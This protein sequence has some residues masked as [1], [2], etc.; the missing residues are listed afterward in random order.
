MTLLELL[1]VISIIGLLAAILI[2]TMGKMLELA[3]SQKLTQHLKQIATATTVFGSENGNRLPSPEYPGGMDNV[4]PDDFPK[5]WDY[6]GTGLWLDGVVFGTIYLQDAPDDAT[7]GGAD[8]GEHLKGTIFENTQS[9]KKDPQER[10]WHRHS[11]AMNA[12]LQYD[13]LYENIDSSD[14]YLT[15]KTMSNLLFAPNA[16]LLIENTESNVVRHGDREAIVQTISEHWGKGGKAIA[17]FLDGHAERLTEGQ[18]PSADPERDPASSKFW[19]GV[20][21]DR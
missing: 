20:D 21:A 17:A 15:E 11:Y 14:P 12:N 10:D 6:T 5:F 9:F 1:I 7:Y 2:P 13:R 19:R 8:D 18:I 3:M 16:M 4:D